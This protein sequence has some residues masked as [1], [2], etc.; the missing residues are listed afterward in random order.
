M[1]ADECASSEEIAKGRIHIERA[2]QRIR[3]LHILGTVV[4]LNMTDVIQQIF[5]VCAYL[6]N[7]QMP[8]IRGHN[9]DSCVKFDCMFRNCTLNM[10]GF[11]NILG[12]SIFNN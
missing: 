1:T 8:I 11:F 2:I 3:T 6:T 10:I 9:N 7:F 12:F 5:T 4:R